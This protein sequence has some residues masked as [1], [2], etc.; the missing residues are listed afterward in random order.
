[1]NRENKLK[2]FDIKNHTF[3]YLDNIININD[4]ILG[5]FLIMLILHATF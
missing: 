1:M 4:L 2:E 3:H 5:V